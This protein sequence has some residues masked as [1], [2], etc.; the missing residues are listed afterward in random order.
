MHG[1]SFIS[2][3]KAK[4]PLSLLKMA[5]SRHNRTAFWTMIFLGVCLMFLTCV[6]VVEGKTSLAKK[7]YKNVRCGVCET[8]MKHLHE[9]ALAMPGLLCYV[10]I[11]YKRA[12]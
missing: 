11:T 8:S 10:Y 12:V 3:A 4:K 5:T 6:H 9:E 1:Q 2:R 7:L